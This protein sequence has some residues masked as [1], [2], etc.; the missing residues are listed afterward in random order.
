MATP[1]VTCTDNPSLE[2]L[3]RLLIRDA[4]CLPYVECDT[5]EDWQALAKQLFSEV[6]DGTLAL[7]VCECEAV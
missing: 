6:A 4:D 3:I 2:T 7:N 1:A 5:R